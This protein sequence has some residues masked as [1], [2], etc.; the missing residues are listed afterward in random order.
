MAVIT[1]RSIQCIGTVSG[2]QLLIEQVYLYENI[3]IKSVCVLV[4]ENM[5]VALSALK[6]A[7]QSN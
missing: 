3:L 2:P 4:L 6:G 1:D 7:R 5:I